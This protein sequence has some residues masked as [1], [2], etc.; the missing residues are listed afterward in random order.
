MVRLYTRCL[1][2]VAVAVIVLAMAE[3]CISERYLLRP[4]IERSTNFHNS[5]QAE[6]WHAYWEGRPA[7]GRWSERILSWIE[8]SEILE[9]CDQMYGKAF[10]KHLNIRL[11]DLERELQPA[12]L[13]MFN[14]NSYADYP[15]RRDAV[16]KPWVIE[17]L[18]KE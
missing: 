15:T 9:T 3:S 17:R 12:A 14:F 7:R 13:A 2:Y 5:I 8:M 10:P 16:P 11:S 18:K 4:E 6:A 1:I